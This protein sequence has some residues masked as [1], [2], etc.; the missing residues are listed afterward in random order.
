MVSKLSTS[1]QDR[2]HQD[3]TSTNFQNDQRK[4]GEKFL[5]WLE[6]QGAAAT[7][8]RLTQ[9]ALALTKPPMSAPPGPKCG[10]CGKGGHKTKSCAGGEG[11]G[12]PWGLAREQSASMERE[13]A[14]NAFATSGTTYHNGQGMGTPPR[15]NGS[16]R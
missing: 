12:N 13:I 3:K 5:A 14:G 11:K 8:A 1:H 7:S 2:W 6:R 15:G 10:A 4:P 9:Q 16:R